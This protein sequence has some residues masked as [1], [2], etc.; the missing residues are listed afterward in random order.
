[1]TCYMQ[2]GLSEKL[3]LQKGLIEKS[4]WLAICNKAWVRKHYMQKGLNDKNY[5]Q[6]GFGEKSL[7]RIIQM[8]FK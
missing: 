3:C 8:K 1:M 2:Q 5:T 4:I 7:E 6:K